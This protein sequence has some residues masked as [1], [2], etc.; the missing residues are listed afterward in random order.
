M[1]LE[2]AIAE[3]LE[4]R[5]T[6]Q[7][8]TDESLTEDY[9]GAGSNKES[10]PSLQGSSKRASFEITQ[11]GKGGAKAGTNRLAPGVGAKEEKPSKQ[12]SSQEP[13]WED[14][15]ATATGKEAAAKMKETDKKPTGKGA[16]AAKNFTTVEDP[17]KVVNASSS[18]GNKGEPGRKT[19]ESIEKMFAD[20]T[21][22]TEEFKTKATGLFEALV[23]A[24]VAAEREA[25]EAEVAEAAV[26]HI[27][28]NEKELTEQVDKYLDY[29]A[30]Q[31]LETHQASVDSALKVEMA[32]SF[33]AGLRKLYEE[34]YVTLPEGGTDVVAELNAKIDELK[35]ELNAT[36]EAGVEVTEEVVSLRKNA[37]LAEVS[38]GLALTESEKLVTLCADVAFEDEATFKDKIAVIRES[39]FPKAGKPVTSLTE[40]K[41][42]DVAPVTDDDKL[43]VSVDPSMEKYVLA[44][45]QNKHF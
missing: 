43:V 16:G 32:D 27:L 24:A 10:E 39:Y 18:A 4:Q 14:L 21:T 40:E 37:L 3:L 26:E 30:E 45:S 5:R 31:W 17:T 33:F 38:V 25:I 7:K 41:G 22:L 28:N 11:N 20:E 1:S 34:H 2:N 8:P 23:T 42:P 35:D 9:P 15:G 44:L 6:E 13:G 19:F 29:I 36:I 12:G